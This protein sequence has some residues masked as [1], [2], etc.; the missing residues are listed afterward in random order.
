M[1]FAK[2]CGSELCQ[3]IYGYPWHLEDATISR[4]I[5]WPEVGF[6]SPRGGGVSV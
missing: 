2:Q 1:L 3:Y 4:P 5:T 6:L